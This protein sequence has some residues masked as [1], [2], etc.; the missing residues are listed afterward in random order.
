MPS[1]VPPLPYVPHLHQRDKSTETGS[2]VGP[3]TGYFWVERSGEKLQML[4]FAPNAS[5][6]ESGSCNN[7]LGEVAG[8]HANHSLGLELRKRMS[9]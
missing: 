4:S 5:R 8:G 9:T 2:H 3:G 6:G 7:G 1:P